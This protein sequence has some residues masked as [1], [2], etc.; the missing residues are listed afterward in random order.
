MPRILV[1][2]EGGEAEPGGEVAQ[3]APGPL[4]LAAG[5]D[6]AHGEPVPL[7]EHP[8]V[9]PGDRPPVE[10]HPP[11]P[12]ACHRRR[13]G[14]LQ[15]QAEVHLLVLHARV[16]CADPGGA[17]SA[18]EDA[19]AHAG[20]VGQPR[21]GV[22]V[23]LAD[24]AHR[25]PLLH[26]GPGRHRRPPE[27]VVELLP[28]HHGEQRIAL[29]PGEGAPAVQGD[30]HGADMVARGHLDAPAGHRERGP[31]QAAATGLVPGMYRPLQHDR[32]GTAAGGGERGRQAGRARADDRY[33]PRL[34]LRHSGSVNDG[35]GCGSR[36][37]PS[38]GQRQA[39]PAACGPRP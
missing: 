5:G 3:V 34:V 39:G 35:R 19:G 7:G 16:A 29:F 13:D 15:F 12:L 10:Q 1:G 9:R 20:P 2:L 21:A 33:V 30:G 22:T 37:L 14:D 32:P 17:V 38:S 31:D 6:D 23:V 4:A 25:G 24:P 27:R 18:D 8:A 36:P 28:R 26:G 11:A